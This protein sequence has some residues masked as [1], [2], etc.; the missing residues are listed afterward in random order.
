MGS[1]QESGLDL[2]FGLHAGS[3]FLRYAFRRLMSANNPTR[4]QRAAS[5][6]FGRKL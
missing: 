4:D 1:V 3:L 6:F 5:G 2:S